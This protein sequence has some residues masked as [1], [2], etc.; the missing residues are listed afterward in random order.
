MEV[1]SQAFE[2]GQ[3]IPSVY[4]CE[5]KNHSPALHLENIPKGTVTLAIIVE[6]PD[7][8]NGTFDH[9]V[10]WNISPEQDLQEALKVSD[11]GVNTYG[12]VGY[13]GPCPPPGHPHRYFFRIYA[14]D[15][16]L[17]LPLKST[18]GDLRKAMEG[19]ILAEGEL[20]GTYQ[21]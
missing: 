10:A 18:K 17:N 21:R 9:W 6:D 1:S 19:H 5:G 3:K 14:L 16:T 4:T 20:M 8:P 2:Y 13:R 15:A 12:S 11:Q 7:A